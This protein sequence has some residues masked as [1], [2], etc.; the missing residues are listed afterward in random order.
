MSAPRDGGTSSVNSDVDVLPW[1][2]NAP[3]TRRWPTLG[4]GQLWV[5]RELVYFFALRDLK[6]R[7]KQAFLGVAWAGIQPLIGALTFT[8][9]F[10]RLNDVEIDGPS[11]FAFALLG[12]GVW[13]YYSTTIQTGTSS[14]LANSDL[15]TKV[16]FPR[17]VAPTSTFVPGLIDL[18]V[19]VVLA[20]VVNVAMGGGISPLRLLF[21]LPS[22]L[23]LLVLAVAGP[24]YLFSAAVVKYRDVRTVVGF[25]IQ[26]LLFTVPIAYPPELVPE[27]WRTVIYLN[28][29]SGAVGLLRWALVSTSIP[30]APQLIISVASAAVTLLIGLVHFRRR[31]REFADLI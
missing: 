22:G 15:L 20:C 2:V 16:A 7:Y 13:G 30:T 1:V 12:S 28:P 6:S 26:F 18:A 17:I 5:H 29:V 19:A 11:Y 10:N 27:G 3:S 31:E 24:V 4:L 25:G 9:L 21:G 8:I 14:L 23:V